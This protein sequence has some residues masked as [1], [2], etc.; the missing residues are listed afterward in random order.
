MRLKNKV[1]LITGGARG[2][3]ASESL[4]FAKEG[5]K[6]AVADIRDQEGEAIV[7]QIKKAGGD[8]FYLHLEVAD[9]AAWEKAIAETVRRYGKLDILV[10][11]AGITAT[12]GVVDTTSEE[13]DRVLDVNAKG[14]FLGC[15]HAIPIMKKNGG[16]SIINISSQM[17][18]VGSDTGSPAYNASKGAVTIFTKSAALRHIRDGIRINSVHPGPIDTPMLREGYVDPKLRDRVLTLTPMGRR[19]RPEEVAQGVLFLASDEASYIV[20]AS[21]VIDGGY[22]AM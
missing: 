21:L 19:G 5:A 14:V 18:I 7:T 6:V 12:H 11:N 3:G 8:A 1:A 2:M 9:E 13:W 22:T 10:N 4:L 15:K 16:G 20:G 17:G